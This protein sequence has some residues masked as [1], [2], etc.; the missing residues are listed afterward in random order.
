[1]SVER[2][3]LVVSRQVSADDITAASRAAITSPVA[4]MGRTSFMTVGNASSEVMPG[5]STLAPIPMRTTTKAIGMAIR[6]AESADD[7][8]TF[9][10]RA[11][12]GREYMSGPSTE[13][14]P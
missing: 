10:S 7:L 3:V 1:M 6:A 14:A 4:P 11:Q 5:N 9:S 2:I 12:N 8:A 13:G